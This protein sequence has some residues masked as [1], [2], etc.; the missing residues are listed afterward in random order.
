MKTLYHLILPLLLGSML[1][2][3][4]SGGSP[5]ARATA[6]P[7]AT[8]T[9]TATAIATV[10]PTLTPT[11]L[12]TPPA[13]PAIFTSSTYVL[14][15][16]PHTYI[17]DTCTYL[18]NRWDPNKSEPGTIVMPVMFHSITEG[19]VALDNQITAYDFQQLMRDIHDQGFESIT[20]GELADFMGSN[21]KIPKRSVLLILDDR[22][23]GAVRQHF[24]PILE[25]YDWTVTLGWL[26]GEGEDSTDKKPA[27][28]INGYPEDVFTSLWEQMEAYNKTGRLDVQAHGF[29]HNFAINPSVSDE[30]IRKELETPIP[31]LE[32][33]FGK[34]PI[35]VIWPG[36]GFTQ[37]AVEIAREVGYRLGFT[38][39]PRG[40]LMYNWVPLGDT[41]DPMRPSYM[42][43]GT[44]G[45]PLMVLPRYWD[46]DVR[47]YLDFIRVMGKEAAA[48]AETNKAVELEYY[49]IVCRPT[50][51]ELPTVDAAPI[52]TP[53]P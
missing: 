32:Q 43:E 20:A 38:V 3:A 30:Y 29:F 13:L 12:R 6:T 36:G 50:F 11:P 41:T 18:L 7:T 42:P 27:S 34:K 2:S 52:E 49:D 10:T 19:A 39:N 45:D 48:Q 51:G 8:L 26:I 4:C 35:A 22:R 25:E 21:A 53:T 23:P 31:I 14:K 33:H 17:A 47:Q 16:S 9:P 37:R 5:F 15:D 44:I 46:T 28:P 1:L 40:P 24:L